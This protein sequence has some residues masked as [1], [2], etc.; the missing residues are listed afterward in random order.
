MSSIA[1]MARMR[2][3]KA[4]KAEKARL[5]AIEVEAALTAPVN[6][7]STTEVRE[8][9]QDHSHDDSHDVVQGSAV[10]NG[11][12]EQKGKSSVGFADL[13]DR[14]RLAVKLAELKK[15]FCLI[16]GAGSGKTTTVRTLATNLLESGVIN[17]LECGTE[18]V[19]VQG[20]PSIAVISYT[21]QAVRNIK[22][23][24]PLEFK[25]H[26]STIHKLLEYVPVQDEVEELDENGLWT[27][28][29]KKTMYYEPTYGVEPNTGHGQGHM[30]P[31][32]QFIVVEEGGSVPVELWHTLL[33]ALPNPEEVVFIFLGD[34]NQLPPVFGDGILGFQ[35]LALP[36]V[37][38][39]Q[40]YRNVG[41]VTQF[42]HKILEGKPLTCDK[43]AE[44]N[45]SDESGT[46]TF[47]PFKKQTNVKVATTT[48]G[49]HFKKLV[50]DGA[51]DPKTDVL[52]I[53]FNKQL[54]T[55]IMNKWLSHAI[56]IKESRVV[57][58]VKA[59]YF[60]KYLAVGDKVLHNKQYCYITKIEPNTSYSGDLPRKESQHMD[61]WGRIGDEYEFRS[62][63]EEMELQDRSVD[64]L[65]E[66][67]YEDVMKEG[68]LKSSHVITLEVADDDLVDEEGNRPTMEIS[69]VGAVNNLLPVLAMSVHK[70]QG[71][72]WRK[73]WAILHH[74]HAV[75][76]K[77]EMLY[78]LITRARQSLEIFYSG[79][80]TAHKIGGSPFQMGIINQEI[81]GNTL[82][83]KLNYFRSKIQAKEIQDAIKE[84]RALQKSELRPTIL[85]T[86]E[87]YLIEH[88]A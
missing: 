23:A 65:M 16:G 11:L 66:Q 14:Q 6:P 5:A 63:I 37:E 38:L 22:E 34:L 30:L 9:L 85:T 36:I 10:V 53:P 18:K 24:L 64:E 32:I 41:L 60:T 87:S 20:N 33:S 47:R 78:T 48:M 61:R 26:C 51:F 8:N 31:D 79:Q 58:E 76:F 44:W 42:A 17:L 75:M 77:R 80:K 54:G 86:I 62:E 70:A 82:E 74:S 28:E 25:A 81:A 40:V 45:K 4:A 88:G 43:I 19:L 50:L 55:D 84:G 69:S 83:T 3:L 46:L 21:N 59:G 27:G 52:L 29:Y 49:A 15:S 35:L 73:V 13:N 39:Q 67:A 56:D 1:L 71:S 7:A 72:E 68:T 57:W 2:A 12:P